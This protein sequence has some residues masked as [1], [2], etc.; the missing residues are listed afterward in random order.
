ME[1]HS[2]QPIFFSPTGNTKKYCTRIAFYLGLSLEKSIDLTYTR[3]RNSGKWDLRGDL[4]IFGTPVYAGRV[5]DQ[6]IKVLNQINGENRWCI[7]LVIN[8]NVS[9]GKALNEFV[10]LLK[11]SNFRIFGAGSF[12]GMHS[13]GREEFPLA[14]NR[15]DAEDFHNVQTFSHQILKKMENP[16]ITSPKSLEIIFQD[17]EIDYSQPH[18][19]YRAC[20]LVPTIKRD[21]EICITCRECFAQCPTDAIDFTTLDID[22]EKCIRCLACVRVCKFKARQ[23]DLQIPPALQERFSQALTQRLKPQWYL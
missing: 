11:S 4:I 14:L 17:P 20:V 22:E 16:G 19:Q 1:F 21:L 10:T 15:P 8:G 2:V 12:T 18:P 9:N 7:A 3:T 5:P 13:F 6:I 23:F